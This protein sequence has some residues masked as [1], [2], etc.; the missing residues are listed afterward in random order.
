MHKHIYI[1]KFMPLDTN[2]SYKYILCKSSTVKIKLTV[3]DASMCLR[4]SG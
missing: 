4:Y 1:N 2:I 3:L